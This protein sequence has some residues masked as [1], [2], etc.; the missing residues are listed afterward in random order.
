MIHKAENPEPRKWCPFNSG[1]EPCREDESGT[2]SYLTIEEHAAHVRERHP[3]V[4]WWLT[5]IGPVIPT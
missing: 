4:A 1:V 2:F 3:S 5:N